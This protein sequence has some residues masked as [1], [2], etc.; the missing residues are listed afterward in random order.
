MSYFDTK[1]F[2]KDINEL[3]KVFINGAINTNRWDD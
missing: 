3:R 1:Q 2:D